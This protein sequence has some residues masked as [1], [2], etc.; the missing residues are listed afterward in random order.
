MPAQVESIRIPGFPKGIYSNAPEDLIPQEN[1]SDAENV[2]FGLLGEVTSRGGITKFSTSDPV[3]MNFG[4]AIHPYI[5]NSL[6]DWLIVVDNDDEVWSVNITSGTTLASAGFHMATG[7]TDSASFDKNLY[8]TSRGS[9]GGHTATYY[10]KVKFDGS[11]WT[12][13]S[14]GT[15]NGSGSEFP[16]ASSLLVAHE[17]MWAGNVNTSGG[18]YP[19]RIYFSDIG[20]A[21]TW[22]ST[23]WIDIDPDDGQEVRNLV[24]FG[25]RIVIFK[26]FKMF[27][28][29]G[30]DESSFALYPVSTSYGCMSNRAAVVAEE[31]LYWIDTQNGFMSFDGADIK[32]ISD[33][34]QDWFDANVEFNNGSTVYTDGSHVY[35]TVKTSASANGYPNVTWVYNIRTESWSRFDAGAADVTVFE[36][37]VYGVGASVATDE[38]IFKMWTG[39]DDDG[40]DFACYLKTGW[41]SFNDDI[42]QWKRVRSMDLALD[43]GASNNSAVT[44]EVFMDYSTS[45]TFSS[46][47]NTAVSNQDLMYHHVPGVYDNDNDPFARVFAF[48]L[49]STTGDPWELSHI[50]LD[51]SVRNQRRRGQV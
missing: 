16:V 15:L 34:I 1:V 45:S 20:D 44:L 41:L 21:E 36:S 2:L 43:A 23:N 37:V 28:L 46:S 6:N 13:F 33:P 17:R 38:G 7:I 26:N 4:R 24:L 39:T 8:M 27:V 50:Q 48:K 49:S 12:Y 14:D 30:K 11:T 29:V 35:F 51:Y 10:N 25:E 5:D 9:D 40:A 19:S 18:P 3:G 22:Q 31:R 47:I 32:R 42:H